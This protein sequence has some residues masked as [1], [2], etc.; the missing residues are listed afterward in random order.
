MACW[1]EF[2]LAREHPRSSLPSVVATSADDGRVAIGGE[3]DGVALV[4]LI[5]RFRA[6]QLPL[7]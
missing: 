3:R 6:D 2:V 7:L 5:Y 4:G 1:D